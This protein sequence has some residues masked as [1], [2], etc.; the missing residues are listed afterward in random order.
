MGHTP[1]RLT[2]RAY[3]LLEVLVSLAILLAGVIAIVN[4]FPLSL[5]AN[6]DAAILSEAAMLAH[7]KAEEIRRDNYPRHN[8]IQAVR[9]LRTPTEP[10]QFPQSP[11]L[12]YSFCGVSLIDPMDD[13][14]DPRDD[15]GVARVIIRYDKSFKRSQDIIYELRFDE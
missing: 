4:F 13:P 3:S 6:N 1:P 8:F 2:Q 5:K 7:Q 11:H 10:I 9:V 14:G 12:A 15:V